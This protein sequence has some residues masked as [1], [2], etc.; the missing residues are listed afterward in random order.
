ML[1]KEEKDYGLKEN[2]RKRIVMTIIGIFLIIG[3]IVLAAF[4]I[5]K[6]MDG[7]YS[8]FSLVFIGFPMIFA[9][10]VILLLF[11]LGKMTRFV[12][13]Q[14]APVSK[15]VANYMM[16]NTKESIGGVAKEVSKNINDGKQ[17]PKHRACLKCG[18]INDINHNFC[19]DCGA[20][21]KNKD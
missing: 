6:L 20:P 13:S 14:S 16:D 4:G 11:N 1:K 17:V 10:L 18:A 21:L 8:L 9:G 2:N 12:A 5:S 19:G 7:D 15:D 3:G